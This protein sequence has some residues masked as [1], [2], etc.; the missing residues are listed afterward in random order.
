MVAEL[1][2]CGCHDEKLSKNHLL[3]QIFIHWIQ[4]CFDRGFLRLTDRHP[5]EVCCE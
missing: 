5:L 1:T 4:G 2:F 3:P